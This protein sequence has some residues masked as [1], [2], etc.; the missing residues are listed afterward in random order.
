MQID[1]MRF[2]EFIATLAATVAWAEPSSAPTHYA[3]DPAKS[4]LKFSFVQAGAK[5]EGRF[6]QARRG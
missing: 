1:D 6:R 2:I 3:L 4:S 5:N